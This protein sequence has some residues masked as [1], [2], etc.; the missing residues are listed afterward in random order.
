MLVYTH[1]DFRFATE[2]EVSHYSQEDLLTKPH[3]Y[4][5]QLSQLVDRFTDLIHKSSEVDQIFIVAPGGT[6]SFLAEYALFSRRQLKIVGYVQEPKDYVSLSTI[7]KNPMV[8]E[9]FDSHKDV[10]LDASINASSSFVLACFSDLTYWHDLIKLK[11]DFS[12]KSLIA[13]DPD[14]KLICNP[15]SYFMN[16]HTWV[17]GNGN[18]SIQGIS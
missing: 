12:S 6:F 10:N 4:G 3:I 11:T 1:E 18:R 17:A 9:I 14:C 13:Y 7:S 15:G 5:Y 2:T 16:S 8:K